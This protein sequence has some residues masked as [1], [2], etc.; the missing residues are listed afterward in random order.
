MVTGCL[1]ALRGVCYGFQASAYP[2]LTMAKITLNSALRGIHG[3]V[4]EWIYKHYADGVVVTRR[5]RMEKVKWSPA[6]RAHR[7][8]VRAAGAF[9]RAVLADPKAKRRYA[10]IAAKKGI[11]LSA[12]TLVEY[13]KQQR[14][15]EAA[16]R[17]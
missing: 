12:V 2:F 17:R 5:P 16:A 1:N 3:R 15:H 7:E 8:K 11:P 13:F 14:A 6:Q 9:Y 4:D 10:A